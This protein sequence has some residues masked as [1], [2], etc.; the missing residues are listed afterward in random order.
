MSLRQNLVIAP[1]KCKGATE[2]I[3]LDTETMAGRISRSFRR[4]PF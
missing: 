4:Y 1:V 2:K 3:Y